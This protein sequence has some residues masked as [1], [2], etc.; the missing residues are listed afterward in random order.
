[1]N[2]LNW[3]YLL[4]GY[5]SYSYWPYITHHGH[6]M[7]MARRVGGLGRFPVGDALKPVTEI[8]V[9]PETPLPAAPSRGERS[10]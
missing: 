6:N 5:N 2:H 10:E 7:A 9:A 1:M 8:A 3:T 4:I